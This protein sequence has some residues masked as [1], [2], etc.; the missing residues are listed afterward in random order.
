MNHSIP[1]MPL[2]IGFAS[3][4][5]WRP[6][7]EHMMFL[8]QL[9]ENAGHHPFFLACDGD[10]PTCY[11]R[12][13]RDTRPS[14]MECITCRLG[15][16]RSYP[17]QT[18]ASM[19]KLAH[20]NR[21]LSV[22]QARAWAA[23]SASTLGRFE[24]E[25]DFKSVA[26]SV[27]RDRLE[28]PV[29][30]A[31]EAARAWIASERLDAVVVFNGRIDLTRSI[32][33]AAKAAG[34][35]VITFE[36]TWF[37]DG[38]QLLPEENCLGLKSIHRLIGEWSSKPLT[39]VQAHTAASYVAAR[40]TT[41][42]TKEWRA[43]NVNS[44]QKGWPIPGGRHRILLLPGSLNEIWGDVGWS[45]GWPDTITAYDALIKHLRLQPADL[46]LRCHPNWAERIGKNDGHRAEAHYTQWALARG[47]HVIPSSDRASTMGLI[48]QCEAVGLGSG[49]AA[50]EAAALGKQVIATAPSS[51]QD[52]GFRTDATSPERLSQLTLQ[53]L[54]P[55][56]QQSIAKDSLRRHVLR[57]IYTMARRMPQYV[58]HVKSLSTTSYS[59]I[60]GASPD[61]LVELIRSGVLQPDDA[62]HSD[63]EEGEDSIMEHMKAGAWD[64]LRVQDEA[65]SLDAR[66]GPKRRWFLQP[67]GIL[68][69]KM[70][71]GDR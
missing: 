24:S 40:F 1:A 19:G 47:I 65:V 14:W 59:Y 2:R 58:E 64:A 42:N 15:G 46:V 12:E 54:L 25:E 16:V 39:R 17:V 53:S 23:S 55:L 33:E 52:A 11:T 22:S 61:R 45:A 28:L 34:V 27:Q 4:Y 3:V 68:R 69:E 50:V 70:P 60:P 20:G 18:V 6:H 71:I 26:F 9:A 7:T 32:Y 56:D 43:Y 37:G 63:C 66:N 8:A 21:T 67:V 30:R 57:Y 41:S 36:R 38:I 62:T 49:S 10:M 51:Y 31:Y 48:E 35:R 29:S 5:A 13:L 44:E